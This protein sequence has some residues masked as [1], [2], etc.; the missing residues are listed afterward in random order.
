MTPVKASVLG[1]LLKQT[2][3]KQEDIQFLVNGFTHG[4][5]LCYCSLQVRRSVSHNLP[6]TV[7]NK[8][9]LWDKLMKEVSLGRVAGPFREPPYDS[10]IQSPIG[11][12]PKDGSTQ[13]RLIFHLSY[14]FSDHKSVNHFIPKE[15]CSVKYNDLDMAVKICLRLSD[16]GTHEVY[17]SKTDGKST[18]RVSPLNRSSWRWLI[19]KA[20]HPTSGLIM[21]FVIN[22]SRLGQV[23]V[24][25]CFNG[26][27]TL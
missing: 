14:N 10:F 15:L 2:S 8:S 23:L 5:D 16:G 27:Q 12:A 21:Y 25:L 11:L 3:M 9:K 22:V 20:E 6:F 17:M 7:G 19:M 26:F 4:F 18:F 24:A 1:K 13:T